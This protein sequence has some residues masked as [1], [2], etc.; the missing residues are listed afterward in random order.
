MFLTLNELSFQETVDTEYDAK[1][2]IED[3]VLLCKTLDSK[4]IL[5]DIILPESFFSLGLYKDYGFT[6]WLNDSNVSYTHQQFF[7]RF[8]DKHRLYYNDE[9]INGE[10]EV[11]IGEHSYLSKGCAFAT[12]HNHILLSFPTNDFWLKDLISGKYRFLDEDGQIS[13]STETLKNIFSNMPK[14]NIISNYT[15]DLSYGITSG[16]DLW[17]KREQLYPNLV[18]CQNV[19][20]QLIDDSEKHH[21][22]AVMKKLDRFQQYFS[23][24]DNLYSPKELGLSARTESESV[25]TDPELKGLRRFRLPDGNEEYF[26]DHVSFNGKYSDGR[27]HFLPDNTNNKCY[28]G[29]IGRHLKTEKY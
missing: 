13:E 17:D 15:K 16:Q 5:D 27:I 22:F 6:Q 9:N 8:L 28:I 20:D 11:C 23:N 2:L 25:K 3:F 18:F 24:C 26:F 29:Y 21:I 4:N 10:F 14:E 7:R 1:K 12:E 19:K